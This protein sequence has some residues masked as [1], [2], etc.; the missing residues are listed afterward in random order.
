MPGDSRYEW[1]HFAMQSFLSVV[2]KL[3]REWIQKIIT[4]QIEFRSIRIRRSKESAAV[5][6]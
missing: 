4:A 3:R 5:L 2:N 1:K 6:D